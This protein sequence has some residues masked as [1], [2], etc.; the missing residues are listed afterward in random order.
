MHTLDSN[1]KRLTIQ[2]VEEN[3]E[4]LELPYVSYADTKWHSHLWKTTDQVCNNVKQ[5][6]T[7]ISQ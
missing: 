1:K 4:Q 3:M 2:S 5:T 7:H 6:F